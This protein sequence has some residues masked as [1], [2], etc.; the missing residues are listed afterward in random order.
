MRWIL[1]EDNV[2]F[3]EYPFSSITLLPS[4]PDGSGRKTRAIFLCAAHR[5]EQIVFSESLAMPFSFTKRH[6]IHWPSKDKPGK[7]HKI[8]DLL[9][10][11][12]RGN[13]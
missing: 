3:H 11:T 8:A 10:Y 13:G 7:T 12:F 5:S 6:L 1:L 4:Q 2:S 9:K